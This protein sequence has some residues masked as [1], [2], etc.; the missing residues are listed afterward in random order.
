MV[1]GKREQSEFN[2][3][4]S[5]L[6]RINA[7]FAEAVTNSMI[8]EPYGWFYALLA[9]FRELS[10]EMNEEEVKW[11]KKE[12]KKINN[13]LAKDTLKYE[14]SQIMSFELHEALTEFELKLR[15]IFKD[16]GLQQKVKDS[17]EE[18]LR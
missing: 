11:F 12:N 2:S 6:N 3:S 7:E 8:P 1:E 10:T 17:A 16:S 15:N 5:Y 14:G 13:I 4:V 18:A 9:I